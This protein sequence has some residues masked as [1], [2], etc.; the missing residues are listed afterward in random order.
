MSL[1]RFMSQLAEYTSTGKRTWRETSMREEFGGIVIDTCFTPDTL[2]WET[3]ISVDNNEDK[4]VIVE[5]YK[6][7]KEAEEGH[8]KWIK[9]LKDNPKIKLKSCISAVDWASENY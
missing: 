5:M 3:G 6:N 1:G 4:W 9:K 2:K 8:K 7:K